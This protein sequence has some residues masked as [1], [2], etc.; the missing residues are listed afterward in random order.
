MVMHKSP[1]ARHEGEGERTRLMPEGWLQKQSH[2][3]IKRILYKRQVL[4]FEIPAPGDERGARLRHDT[5]KLENKGVKK[6]GRCTLA[7]K[8]AGITVLES[9]KTDFRAESHVKNGGQYFAGR[10]TVPRADG[11]LYVPGNLSLTLGKENGQNF[12]GSQ[13]KPSSW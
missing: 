6:G 4:P 2:P 5:E 11:H 8:K 13:T 7:K 1:Q 10:G 9:D 12:K 3:M